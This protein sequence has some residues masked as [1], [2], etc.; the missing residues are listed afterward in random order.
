LTEDLHNLDA[1]CSKTTDFSN[2]IDNFMGEC[3]FQ[4]TADDLVS[5]RY[6][7]LFFV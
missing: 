4:L 3:G 6:T 7:Y 2:A 5:K 1:D